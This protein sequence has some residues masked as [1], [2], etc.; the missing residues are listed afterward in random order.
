MK[1][2]TAVAIGRGAMGEVFRA[3]DPEAKRPVALKLFPPAEQGA[4]DDSAERRNREAEAQQRLDHPSI[5]SI[6]DVGTMSS[7]RG[8]IAMRFVDGEPLDQVAPRLPLAGRVAL[9]RQVADA[10]ACAHRAG[11]I[12]RDLKPSNVL[13][14]E[15]DDG[16]L[17]PFVLDF[18][19]VRIAD[20]TQLTETGQVLGTPRL[21][22]ARAGAWRA[23]R[24][25]TE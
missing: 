6:Y 15:Q 14:E 25:R 18:G 19:I 3:W 5:C 16:R 11:L 4:E 8:Y 1:Y 2:E 23:R 12:H 10:V 9:I 17:R 24:R 22:V 13:V 7:G 21:P 20:R